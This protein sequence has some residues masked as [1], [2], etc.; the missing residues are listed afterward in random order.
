MGRTTVTQTGRAARRTVSAVAEFGTGIGAFWRGLWTFVTSPVLWLY[1]VVPA[2]AVYLLTFAGRAGA[3][4]A[5]ESLTGWAVG[6]AEDWPGILR[7]ALENTV[8]W[9]LTG[10]AYMLI[11]FLVVPLTLIVGAPF[12]VLTVRRMERRLGET[13]DRRDRPGWLRASGFVMSQ[14]ILVTLVIAFGGLVLVPILL[15]PGINVLVAL[16]VAVLVNGFV[17]GLLAV[18]PTLHHRGVGERLAHLK[19]V[20]RRRWP[21]IGFGTMSVLVLSVP[22]APLRWF[23]IPAVFIGAVL[24]HRKFPHEPALPSS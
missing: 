16:T 18:G 3:D 19:Y 21:T 6:F 20:W 13:V 24:L 23:T 11:G 15:I 22:F 9:G 10:L 5:T 14:T 12:L 1:A 17:I 7:W 4:A 8:R 2:V